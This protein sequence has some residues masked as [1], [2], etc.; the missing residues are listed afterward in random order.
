MGEYGEIEADAVQR[1]KE[2]HLAPTLDFLFEKISEENF[3]LT[4]STFVSAALSDDT[5]LLFQEKD[6]RI[7]RPQS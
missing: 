3:R 1:L 5:G 6:V 4:P 2:T 7:G